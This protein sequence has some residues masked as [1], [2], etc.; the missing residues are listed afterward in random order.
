MFARF[1]D[2]SIQGSKVLPGSRCLFAERM[3]ITYPSLGQ[4]CRAGEEVLTGYSAWQ[5]LCKMIMNKCQIKLRKVQL[6]QLPIEYCPGNAI[7]PNISAQVSAFCPTRIFFGEFKICLVQQVPI[8]HSPACK[9]PT[10]AK[11]LLDF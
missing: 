2:F 8:L 1:S 5:I 3:R 6:G 11:I 10:Q 4:H 9:H 7:I